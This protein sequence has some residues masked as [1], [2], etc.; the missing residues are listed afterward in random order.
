MNRR[1]S[2]LTLL[3]T[4][5][6]TLAVAPRAKADAILKLNDGAGNSVTV[7]QAGVVTFTGSASGT[8]SLPSGGI[9]FNGT[10]G[11]WTVNVSTGS[12][13]P[14]G[15][16]SLDLNSINQTSSVGTID[17]QVSENGLA[18]LVPSLLLQIGGTV[19]GG[20]ATFS[21]F[22][23]N[24]NALLGHGSPIGTLGPFAFA[25][26]TAFAGSITGSTAGLTNPYSLTEDVHL[27]STDSKFF[28]SGDAAVQPVPEPASM[29][30]FGTGLLGLG[31]LV[32]RRLSR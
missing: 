27:N 19:A 8:G 1:V 15:I 14:F 7:T 11:S 5:A 29:L 26:N 17:I 3:L 10:V 9:S 31:G 32:R 4:V 6:V 24:S 22:T 20:S 30:L 12:L 23:D 21:A 16:P 2:L 28:Y 25:S 13:N 18:S